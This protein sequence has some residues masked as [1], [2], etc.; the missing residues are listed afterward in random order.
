M[1]SNAAVRQEPDYL[2]SI[3][4]D[5]SLL[6][7]HALDHGKLDDAKTLE[8]VLVLQQKH[9]TSALNESELTETID[10]YEQMRSQVPDVN[11]ASVRETH[12]VQQGYWNSRVGRHLM[13]LW[14]ITA[15]IGLLIFLYTI[16]EYRVS[17]YDVKPGADDDPNF[18]MWIR[19]QDYSSFLVPFVYGTLGACAFLLRN[20]GEKLRARQFDPSDIPQHWNRLFLGGLSGGMVI[21]FANDDPD[22]VINVVN[23]SVGALGF[24]AGYSIDVLFNTIDRLISAVLPSHESSSP[25]TRHEKRRNQQL[26]RKYM[27]QLNSVNTAEEKQLLEKILKDLT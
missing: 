14:G 11:A 1:N 3:L 23:I 6:G 7:R 17:Y 15:L 9:S 2:K 5:A 18:L 26:T 21:L 4:D 22:S 16:L 27:K 12:N 24:I 10:L 20:M 13:M 19:I 8:R 25:D